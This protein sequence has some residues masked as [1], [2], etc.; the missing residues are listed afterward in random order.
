MSFKRNY[1]HFTSVPDGAEVKK[2][3]DVLGVTPVDIQIVPEGF[4]EF[5]AVCFDGSATICTKTVL[6]P[7]L[8]EKKVSEYWSALTKEQRVS[9]GKF[10]ISNFVTIKHWRMADGDANCMGNV[11]DFRGLYCVSATVI[12]MCRMAETYPEVSKCYYNDVI[13]NIHCYV[14]MSGIEVYHLPCY[15]CNVMGVGHQYGHSICALQV[16]ENV[17]EFNSW[18]FF[19]YTTNDI[20]PGNYQMPYDSN[21]TVVEMIHGYAGCGG[22]ATS[23]IASWYIDDNGVVT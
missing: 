19:Q 12:R 4:G 18:L 20:Q 13:G 1:L 22:F 10:I 23:T 5:V 15:P 3:E 21:V 14:D 6:H 11:G 17:A 9:L 7:Y 16:D 2:G 8:T